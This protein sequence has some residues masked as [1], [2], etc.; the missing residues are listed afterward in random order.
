MLPVELDLEI[1]GP[2]AG[3]RE[4]ALQA[5]LQI[6]SRTVDDPVAK[7]DSDQDPDRQRQEDGG[8]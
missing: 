2:R 5:L 8:E 1:V 3:P 6:P 7:P 4:V